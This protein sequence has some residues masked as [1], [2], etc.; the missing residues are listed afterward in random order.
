[1]LPGVT[2]GSISGTVTDADT[3]TPIEGATVSVEVNGTAKEATTDVAGAYS[4]EEV[5][6]G[7]NFSS[8]AYEW[9][10]IANH[11]AQFKASSKAAA[12]LTAAEPTASCLQPLMET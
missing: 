10:V 1:M 11:R 3:G 5:P 7:L 12:P 2:T 9:L 6:A 8:T 4:I